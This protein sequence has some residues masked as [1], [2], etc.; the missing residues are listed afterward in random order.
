MLEVICGIA[1]VSASEVVWGKLEDE[2]H[3]QPVESKVIELPGGLCGGDRLL[4]SV[5][6]DWP[7]HNALMDDFG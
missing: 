2:L 3:I 5:G 7:L 1:H 6:H 4:G